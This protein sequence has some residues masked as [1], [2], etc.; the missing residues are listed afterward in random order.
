MSGMLV[1]MTV[2]GTLGTCDFS[3]VEWLQQLPT[4][5]Y[6]ALWLRWPEF[7]LPLGYNLY[8]VSFHLEPVDVDWVTK[9]AVKVGSPVVLLSD[10]N[11]YNYRFPSN[12]YSYTYYYWHHQIDTIKEW[13]PSRVDKNLK[14]KASAFCNR[15][16]QS[17][18][19]V[20]A[21][22]AEYLN[23][24]ALLKLDNWLEEK[25]VHHRELTGIKKLDNLS[26]LF[27][28]RYFGKSYKID[29]YNNIKDNFQSITA[30][31]WSRA[32]QECVFNFT[33]ES[34]HYSYM[35]VDEHE[36]VHPGP[37]LT[38]KTLKCLAGETPFIAVGQF[39]T[40]AS[41]T[42]LGFKF[43][44]GELDL[45]WDQDPGNL[46]RLISIIDLIVQ[47]KNYTLQDLYEFTQES[48]K[49]NFDYIWSGDFTKYITNVNEQIVTKI[50]KNFKK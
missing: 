19:I 44:Y 49:F 24:Q 26:D 40:Y 6:Y 45:S 15:I 31:P 25:N 13:F 29:D 16:T 38:E 23:N 2:T 4:N 43:D 47:M 33:N 10:S 34:F 41:L 14:F 5:T 32:Y 46:T 7:D 48:S 35:I 42:K 1:P 39:D 30:D 17:K 27:W 12:V 50:L 21:A 20:F 11:Y 18:M 3:K 8:V 28:K 37:F 9:Q 36:F 22:L